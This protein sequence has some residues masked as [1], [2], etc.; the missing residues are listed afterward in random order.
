MPEEGS[1]RT[2]SEHLQ[3]DAGDAL[4]SPEGDH[5]HAEEHAQDSSDTHGE[6][7]AEVIVDGRNLAATTNRVGY[8][9]A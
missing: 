7:Q 5:H 8:Q 9:H 1:G 2:D 6:Q 4:G 3:T